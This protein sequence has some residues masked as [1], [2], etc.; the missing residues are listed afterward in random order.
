MGDC[1]QLKDKDQWEYL[2]CMGDVIVARNAKWARADEVY[3]DCIKG[4]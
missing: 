2:Q 4:K 1:T 3:E